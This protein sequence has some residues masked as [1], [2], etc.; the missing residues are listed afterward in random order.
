VVWVAPVQAKVIYTD[1]RAS[2]SARRRRVDH[3]VSRRSD[4]RKDQRGLPTASEMD[5]S[6]VVPQRNKA[7]GERKLG[8]NYGVGDSA[9]TAVETWPTNTG[10]ELNPCCKS[11]FRRVRSATGTWPRIMTRRHDPTGRVRKPIKGSVLLR[12][13]GVA[14]A[15][16]AAGEGAQDVLIQCAH[17]PRAGTW[18][19]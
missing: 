15:V 6:A 3:G 2:G 5:I 14:R 10:Q 9:A 18:S 11:R 4:D 7:R 8:P 16:R 17:D 13:R 12:R 19:R 1:S